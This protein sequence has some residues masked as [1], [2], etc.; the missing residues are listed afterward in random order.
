MAIRFLI[1]CGISDVTLAGFDGYQYDEH[2]NYVDHKMKM[3]TVKLQK[4][5]MNE[6]IRE[7]IKGMAGQINIRTLTPSLY[8]G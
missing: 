4:R 6:L 1:Q 3:E 5:R 2:L 8:F 7:E